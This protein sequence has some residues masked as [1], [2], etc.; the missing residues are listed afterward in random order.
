M[1]KLKQPRNPG[2]L[3]RK[4]YTIE[5]VVEKDKCHLAAEERN[6]EGGSLTETTNLSTR[7]KG[8]KTREN[9]KPRRGG[10]RNSKRQR[11]VGKEQKLGGRNATP[12]SAQYSLCKNET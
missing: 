5:S 9:N 11:R 10:K 4:H 2:E 8:S 1:W 7:G 12:R 6:T 3:N